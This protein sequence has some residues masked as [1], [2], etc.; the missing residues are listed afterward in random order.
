M[1]LSKSHIR[2]VDASS[3][4]KK[5]EHEDTWLLLDESLTQIIDIPPHSK[6][7]IITK[8]CNMGKSDKL[9]SFE[10]LIMPIWTWKELKE[11]NLMKSSSKSTSPKDLK[12]LKDRFLLWGG[13]PKRLFQ[14]D[15]TI[16]KG[17]ED[18]K[19]ILEKVSWMDIF[20]NAETIGINDFDDRIF[21]VTT[22]DYLHSS[23]VFSSRWVKNLVLEKLEKKQFWRFINEVF[24]ANIIPSLQKQFFEIIAARLLSLGGSFKRKNLMTEA[25]EIIDIVQGDIRVFEDIQEITKDEFW[26]PLCEN[27]AS[28]D[29]VLPVYGLFHITTPN[30]EEYRLT[31]LSRWL[32]FYDFK[33]SVDIN[34]VV[35]KEDFEYFGL[36]TLFLDEDILAVQSNIDKHRTSNIS[37]LVN[38]FA[39]EIDFNENRRNVIPSQILVN[40]FCLC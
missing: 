39:I 8:D 1:V 26:I 19:E 23:I 7:V 28:C 20:S 17:K 36:Q 22:V 9:S 25:E 31:N 32:K 21:H 35:S 33:R 38:Q 18:V 15:T 37:P 5:L 6:R 12:D 16:A 40:L 30:N 4:F 14:K 29:F 13:I 24:K 27:T 2:V 3:V 11:F 10:D 34:F